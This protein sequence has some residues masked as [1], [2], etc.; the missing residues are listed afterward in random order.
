M[1]GEVFIGVPYVLFPTP[2]RLVGHLTERDLQRRTLG[3]PNVS[4][5]AQTRMTNVGRP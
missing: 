2:A 5:H 1:G 3:E 4:R